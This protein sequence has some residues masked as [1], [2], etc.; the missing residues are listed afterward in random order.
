VLSVHSNLSGSQLKQQLQ[1]FSE[2]AAQITPPSR[3]DVF[4]GLEQNLSLKDP[5]SW[6]ALLFSVTMFRDAISWRS[7]MLPVKQLSLSTT[8]SSFV[9]FASDD[10]S[11]PEIV[12][13]PRF[14]SNMVSDQ[15]EISSGIVPPRL[16][17]SEEED[18]LR[19]IQ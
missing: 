13:P 16:F 11:V 9:K 7:G 17:Q 10:G 8:E 14:I 6:L 3:R 18:R 5:V 2:S 4:V 15:M 1:A 19:W 12:P